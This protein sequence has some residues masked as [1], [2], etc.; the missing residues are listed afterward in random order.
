MKNLSWTSLSLP[1]AGTLAAV[2]LAGCATLGAAT[3]EQQ[4]RER[5]TAF[6]NARLKA[7]PQT[8]YGLLTP[9]YRSLRSEKEFVQSNNSGVSAQK[10]EVGD[11]TCE[12]EKCT[13]RI[14][15]TAKPSIPGL[16]LPVITNYL[17]DIWLKEQGQWWRYVAP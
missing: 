12:E 16:T 6:W 4:V 7:D 3:P 15:I 14:G 5:A 2:V 11:V 9:A 13:V 10:V 17:D 1:L 8:A